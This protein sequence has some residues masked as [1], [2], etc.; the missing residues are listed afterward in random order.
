MRRD[1]DLERAIMLAIEEQYNPGDGLITVSV[2]CY[3]K[4]VVY[5][6]AKLLYQKGFIQS[7][8]DVKTT[9]SID[10][11]VGNLSSEG[12]D[13]VESIRDESVWTTTKEFA[14]DKGLPFVAE[15]LKTVASVVIE[16]MT[17]AAIASFTG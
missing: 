15:T 7:F 12:F 8:V 6:H 16:S 2:P 9:S 5:E 10:F 13:Y 14:K 4:E 3:E 17:K 1:V 11:F